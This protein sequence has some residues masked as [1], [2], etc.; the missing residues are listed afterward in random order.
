MAASGRLTGLLFELSVEQTFEN[1]GEKNIEAVYTFPVPHRAVLLGLELEIG[2]RKLSAVAVR[3]QAASKRYE[4]AIDEGNTAALLEQAG[5]GLYTL[6]LGNL[7]AGE[8]AVIRYRYAELLKQRECCIRL[9]AEAV[10]ALR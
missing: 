1:A 7:L 10:V 6:S 2:E 3:K 8:R 5:D 9:F 4:E